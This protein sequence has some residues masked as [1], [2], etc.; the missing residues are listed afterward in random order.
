M[1]AAREPEEDWKSLLLRS[2]QITQKVVA[3]K[4][5]QN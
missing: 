2:N 4:V 3:S 5:L 1:L